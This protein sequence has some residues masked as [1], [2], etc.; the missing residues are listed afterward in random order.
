MAEICLECWNKLT[1]SNHTEKDYVLS[2]DLYLCENCEEYKRVI[3]VERSWLSKKLYHITK[4][5]KKPF[6]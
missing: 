2:D 3:I 4:I 6:C 5:L 1:S